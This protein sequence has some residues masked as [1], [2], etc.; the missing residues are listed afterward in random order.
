MEFDTPLVQGTLV[1]RYKR[2]LADVE[3]DD[4]TTITAH[5][6]NTG[7]MAG[8]AEPG[9]KVWLR[10]NNNPKRKYR[11]SWEM[12]EVK[13][14]TLVGINTHLTNHLVREAIETGQVPE[15]A[16]YDALRTE[17]A[18]GSEKS[19][20]DILL[21]QDEQRIYIEVKNVTLVEDNIAFFPDAVSTRGSK[22]LRELA[23]VVREGHRGI[24]FFCVQRNDAAEVRPADHIDPV[25]GETLREVAEAGVEIM[26]W[27][28]EP[29]PQS[30]VL[31]KPLPVSLASP[32]T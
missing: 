19:R 15:L 23:G 14:G 16:Q 28:A 5:T 2:F 30:I 26:A 12:V 1:K 3:L 18:Y 31:H 10:D 29:N 4:G 24:L 32:V 22:H 8:C 17:V 25:Y 6:P 7:S 27:C 20:I 13:P 11:L 9:M 21:T